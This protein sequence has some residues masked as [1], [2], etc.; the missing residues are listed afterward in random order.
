MQRLSFKR[1]IKQVFRR[2]SIG[3]LVGRRDTHKLGA[4][5]GKHGWLVKLAQIGP[6][7]GDLDAHHLR[8]YLRALEENR[9]VIAVVGEDGNKR[10]EIAGLLKGYG[11]AYINSY[12]MFS[13][14]GLA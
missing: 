2:R 8:N 13:I 4:A 1:S 5:S 14:E 6:V 12:G 3:V 9:T 10:R 11:A 7:L